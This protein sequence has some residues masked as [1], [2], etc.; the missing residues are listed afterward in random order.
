LDMV[1]LFRANGVLIADCG[2]A[3][4]GPRGVVFMLPNCM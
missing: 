3:W 1:A 2:V 4:R